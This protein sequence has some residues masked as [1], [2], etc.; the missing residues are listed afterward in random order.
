MKLKLLHKIILLLIT[1]TLFLPFNINAKTNNEVYSPFVILEKTN[2]TGDLNS[3]DAILGNVDDEDSVAW[4]LQK[5][6]NYLKILGP[7]LAVVLS[8]IDF[9]KAIV[10]SDEESMKKTQIRFKNRMIA[11][12]LLF[13]IPFVVEIML[14][15]LGITAS[16][17]S[18][19]L[20]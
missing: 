1:V 2:N 8:S 4:L 20:S 5:I 12:V 9:A 16:N 19:G 13:F 11:A 3:C 15:L 14:N 10:T 6:L 7:S 18:C 17:A